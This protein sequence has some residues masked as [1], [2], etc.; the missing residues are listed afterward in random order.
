MGKA[1][2][3][4]LESILDALGDLL[5]LWVRGIPKI[6]KEVLDVATG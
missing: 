4:L 2:K 1:G 6:L 3:T 5:P